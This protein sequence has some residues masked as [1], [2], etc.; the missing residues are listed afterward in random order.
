MMKMEFNNDINREVYELLQ[1]KYLGGTKEERELFKIAMKDVM[2]C[3]Q[4]EPHI[5]VEE[6]D[7][8]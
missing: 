6:D 2:I 7:G 3:D 4:I 1:R 8:K 5:D